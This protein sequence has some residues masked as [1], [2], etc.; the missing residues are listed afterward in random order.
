MSHTT[1]DW[2][3]DQNVRS[4]AQMRQYRSIA[5][6]IARDLPGADVLDWG[7]G[8]GQVSDLMAQRGLRVTSFEYD[9]ADKGLRPLPRYPHLSAHFSSEPV[10][11]PFDDAQFDAVV[12]CG[13]LEHVPDPPGS[14]DELRRVLRPGGTVYVYNLANRRSYLERIAKRLGMYYHG[15]YPND[16]VY[17]LPEANALMV[18]SGYQVHEIR[19][20]NMLPL[21]VL[22]GTIGKVLGP[23]VWL[24]NQLLARVPGLNLFA[25]NVELIATPDPRR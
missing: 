13:V 8:Y 2:D 21:T 10:K 24:L 12:S 16:R 23:P 14:L 20:A 6:R 19:M 5:D 4:D 18:A 7:C 22:T 9:E 3:H 1:E 11:L 25:T 17:T 15:K